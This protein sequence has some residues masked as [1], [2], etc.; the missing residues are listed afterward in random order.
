MRRR[1][2]AQTVLKHFEGLW[3]TLAI[4]LLGGIDTFAILILF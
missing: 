4:M 3:I 2:L 1:L